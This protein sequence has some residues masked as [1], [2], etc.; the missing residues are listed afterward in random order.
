MLK[1]FSEIAVTNGKVI[2]S[3]KRILDSSSQCV[4]TKFNLLFIVYAYIHHRRVERYI[5][6][7]DL[8][9]RIYSWSV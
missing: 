4:F 2:H 8:I 6:L 1:E 3:L 5:H 9:R 7:K